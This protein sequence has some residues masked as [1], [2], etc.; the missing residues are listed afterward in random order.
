[1]VHFINKTKGFINLDFSFDD[2]SKKEIIQGM[3]KEL[4]I[5]KVPFPK[6]NFSAIAV[7]EYVRHGAVIE[8]FWD[9]VVS[10][11]NIIGKENLYCGKFKFSGSDILLL[12]EFRCQLEKGAFFKNNRG[13]GFVLGSD[14]LYVFKKTE[15]SSTNKF[16]VHFLLENQSNFINSSF[17]FNNEKIVFPL[18]F[19]SSKIQ[20]AKIALPA[21]FDSIRIGEFNS[22]GNVW[23]QFLNPKEIF[24]NPLLKYKSFEKDT[25]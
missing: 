21:N 17:T 16:M 12:N 3:P 5:F 10:G 9:T 7:G 19:S 11:K 18:D 25:I 15:K 14:F 20:V 8:K 23:L 6:E 2:N 24:N 22:K 1:M 4:T 13:F